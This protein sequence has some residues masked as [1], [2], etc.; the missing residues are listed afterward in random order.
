[1]KKLYFLLFALLIG[2]A[3][4]GQT[5]VFQEN[6]EGTVS[7]TTSIPEQTDGGFDYFTV[8]NGTTI[9]ATYNSPEGFNFFA[10]H[11]L[12]ADGM[13]SPATMTFDD[14]NINSF[15]DLTFAILLAEDDD[16]SNQDWDSTDFLHIEYDIDNSGT[17]T[18]LLWIENDGAT[19]NSAP[20]QDTDFD[21]NGD[22]IEVTDTFTEFIAAIPGSGSVIDI[23]I[24]FGGLTSSDEDIALDNIRIIDGFVLNPSI[25]I[26]APVNGSTFAPGTTSVDLEWTTAN[27][28]GGE[29]VNVIV[30]GTPNN[31][32]VTATP[33]AI[34]TIDGTSYDVTV[35]LV[36]GG[37]LDSDMISFDVGTLNLV[38]DI[39]ALRADVDANGLGRFYEISGGS[40]VTHTDGFRNRRWIQDTNIAGILI[41]DEANIITTTYNVGDLVTGLRGTTEISNGL[42]RFIPTSDA[43]IISSSGNAVTPQV[44]GI[45][46]FNAAPDNYESE[47]IQV[48]NVTFVEGDG[49][50]TFS[51]GT[52]Y[53]LRD[54]SMNDLVKRTDFFSA[55]Y[56]GEIIPDFEL[57]SVIGV[58]GEF[59]GTSQIYVRDLNDLVLSNEGFDLQK[60]SIYPNPT[61]I[62]EVT[63][64]TTNSSPIQV[65]VY[66]ILGKQVQSETISNNRLDVSSLRSGIYLLRLTQDGNSSTKKLIIE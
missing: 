55:D 27:L 35:Q 45:N 2:F 21:G 6:F 52:N 23:R 60:F 13:M 25:S 36:D 50:S 63:I 37:V 31:V 24:T 15:T 28:N 29:T 26:S 65:K 11:D 44:V 59:N 1:M 10:A 58:A 41:Y 38:A 49:S 4:F 3:S 47:L 39:N 66:D 9:G 12:D 48:N 32:A 42:L 64:S 54:A 17:F 53:T 46:T 40:L 19:F 20:F 34:T 30:N 16:G 7:Y 8:T 56:I 22:G 62:G 51:T 5:V 57:A 14:I 43:G 61:N 18:N 33:Y